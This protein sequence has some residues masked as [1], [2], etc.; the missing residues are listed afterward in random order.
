MTSTPAPDAPPP[1][2]RGRRPIVV[3]TLVVVL[4]AVGAGIW[5]WPG[6]QWGFWIRGA[7]KREFFDNLVNERDERI[8]DKIAA[9]MRDE[10]L[11][12]GLRTVL[13]SILIRRDR[14]PLVERALKDGDLST[15]TIAL[16]A[17]NRDHY[18]PRYLDDLQYRVRETLLDWVH[19]DG[20]DTRASALAML[21]YPA[22]KSPEI[23]PVVR[24]LLTSAPDSDGRPSADVPLRSAAIS[25][26]VAYQDCGSVPTLAA[27][28]KGDPDPQVRMHALQG[29]AQF[30]DQEKSPC[31]GIVT[32]ASLGDLAVE[33]LS[34]PGDSGTERGFR[35]A[36]LLLLAAHPALAKGNLDAIRA[37]LGATVNHIER[38]TA[39]TALLA[40]KDERVVQE[41]P[42][43]FHDDA[44]NVRSEAATTATWKSAPYDDPRF[45][46][47]LVGYLRDETAPDTFENTFLNVLAH[48]HAV[49]GSWVGLPPNHATGKGA[50]PEALRPFFRDLYFKGQAEGV[51]RESVADAWFRWLAEQSGR[52]LAGVTAAVR[53]RDAFW[54]KARAGD[55]AG[56]K[57]ALA[58][59]DGPATSKDLFTYEQGWLL[60]HG[61]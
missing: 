59:P 56:A 53:V 40:S 35:M 7:E 31:A 27:L 47:C 12:A 55:V 36:A 1:A 15:R 23:L 42:R 29:L 21:T 34:Y 28:V 20:D 45:R 9:A 13:A 14:L 33:A 60:V 46:S 32:D 54:A 22:A 6:T 44:A 39:L 11:G 30:H 37:R 18:F 10:S 48:L 43:W 49:A 51:T 26:L 2:P 4:V 16:T 61:S 24:A 50:S 38:R 41:F 58:D 19:R 8:V 5:L 25:T 17:L 57:A 52:D 3:G